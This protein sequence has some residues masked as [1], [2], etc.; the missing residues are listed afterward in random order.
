MPTI[1][2]HDQ[3]ICRTVHAQGECSNKSYQGCQEEFSMFKVTLVIAFGFLPQN[4]GNIDG[5]TQVKLSL[6]ISVFRTNLELTAI[7]ELFF[8][9]IERR[10]VQKYRINK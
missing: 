8:G 4:F 6:S 5:D 9:L 3:Q 1:Y 2:H 10:L 7:S